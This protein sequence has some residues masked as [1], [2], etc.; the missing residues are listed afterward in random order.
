MNIPKIESSKDYKRFQLLNVN[1]ETTNPHVNKFIDDPTFPKKFPY[2]PIVV[3]HKY[4]II[5]GQHRFLAA[6]HLNIPV[7]FIIDDEAVLNDIALRNTQVK[8]WSKIDFFEFY[9]KQGNKNYILIID[10][11]RKHS[12]V[13]SSITP[14]LYKIIGDTHKS[15]IQEGRLSL[16][17]EQQFLFENFCSR[18]FP[19]YNRL[20]AM[21]ADKSYKIMGSK[22]YLAALSNLYLNESN[23]FEKFL[24]RSPIVPADLFVYVG[25]VEDAVKQIGK[26]CRWSSRG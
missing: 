9:A 5:D 18:V 19:V 3:D 4:N 22:Q 1:R 16:D 2:S 7:Y 17:S 20:K 24:S 12:I 25:C 26:I 11:M 10:T 14:I 13:Y 21:R 6:K 23:L 15:F 8:K